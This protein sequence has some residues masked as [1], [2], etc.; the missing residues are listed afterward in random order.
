MLPFNSIS[1]VC[2]ASKERFRHLQFDLIYLGCGLTHYLNEQGEKFSASI[3]SRGSTLLLELPTFLLD[4]KQEQLEKRYDEL[5]KN[6]GCVPQDNEELKANA[7]K[8]YKYN[9]S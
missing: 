4:L 7:V 6:I 1:D 5:A 3:M 8:M 9:R 2:G